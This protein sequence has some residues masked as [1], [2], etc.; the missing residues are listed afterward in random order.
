MTAFACLCFAL[1]LLLLAEVLNW[2]DPGDT[3]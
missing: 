1:G 2:V 3:P